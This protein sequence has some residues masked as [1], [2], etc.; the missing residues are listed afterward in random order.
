M[1]VIRELNK[2]LCRGN[3]NQ[4]CNI[5][6]LPVC[7]RMVLPASLTAIVGPGPGR[8]CSRNDARWGRDVVF[9][10]GFFPL[11]LVLTSEKHPL[12]NDSRALKTAGLNGF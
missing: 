6:Y 12:R 3:Q 4:F 1:I 5:V 10:T 8:A 7:S 11:P 9:R 2:S